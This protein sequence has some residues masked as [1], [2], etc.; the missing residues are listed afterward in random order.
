MEGQIWLTGLVFATCAIGEINQ[1]RQPIG[2]YWAHI[3]LSTSYLLNW[4]NSNF[5]YR[6]DPQKMAGVITF[7]FA[8]HHPNWANV[9]ALLYI[10]LIADE[11][12]LVIS[13]ADEEAQCL[14]QE[15]L[16]RMQTQPG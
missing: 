9:Q 10:L 12:Q 4:K 14:H 8:T 7:I 2:S 11:R 16:N 13:K 1:E 5:S 3:P 6:E 15:N